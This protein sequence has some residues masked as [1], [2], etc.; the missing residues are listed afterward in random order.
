MHF[1]LATLFGP[2]LLKRC[3]TRR[4]NNRLSGQMFWLILFFPNRGSRDLVTQWFVRLW[5]CWRPP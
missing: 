4:V 3:E 2:K 5:A 1:F